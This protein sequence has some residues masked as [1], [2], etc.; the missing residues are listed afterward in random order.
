MML[1]GR[2]DGNRSPT[3]RQ[4]PTWH[5]SCKLALRAAFERDRMRA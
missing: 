2:C 1:V 3:V 5:I 4:L